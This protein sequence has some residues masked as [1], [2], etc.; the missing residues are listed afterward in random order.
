MKLVANGCSHTHGSELY[1]EKKSIKSKVL[2]SR[3]QRKWNLAH[4]FSSTI[5]KNLN[6]QYENLSTP[7]G[8]NDKIFRTTID[9]VNNNNCS[10]VFFLIG[11]TGSCRMEIHNEKTDEWY[12]FSIGMGFEDGVYRME[13]DF[14][15]FYDSYILYLT[16]N[17]QGRRK[18]L[19]YIQ[20][21]QT[22]LES[23]NIKYLFFNAVEKLGHT[24]L[25]LINRKYFFKPRFSYYDTCKKEFEMLPYG[26]FPLAA[27][28]SYADSLIPKIKEILN[29]DNTK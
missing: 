2:D 9:Y 17:K 15:D 7:G 28:N 6:L 29:E 4:C 16:S 27:H 11:W 3:Q 8:S 10:D 14:K 19:H 1:L 26:H 13:S 22:F 20:T 18:R 5:S 21:L 25:N 23:K 12:N 24:D